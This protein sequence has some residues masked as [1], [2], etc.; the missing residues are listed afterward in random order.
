MKKLLSNARRRVALPRHI[1][2]H[3]RL[4]TGARPGAHLAR[5]TRALTT[6][7]VRDFPVQKRKSASPR[8]Q[9]VSEEKEQGFIRYV[10]RDSD[11]EMI[12]KIL[13]AY[14]PTAAIIEAIDAGIQVDFKK[15]LIVIQGKKPKEKQP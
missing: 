12:I 14:P 6:C 8:Q 13:Q 15:G 3:R 1:T 7:E 2:G 11:R 4:H 9:Y 10:L 5:G